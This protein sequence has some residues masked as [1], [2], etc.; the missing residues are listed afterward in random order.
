MSE[1]SAS[2]SWWRTALV[3]AA[4]VAVGG[5]LGSRALGSSQL[6]DF[7]AAGQPI[8]AP[9]PD[10]FSSISLETFEGKLVGMRG[11]PVV[12]NIWASWCAP[13]RTE[14]PLLQKAADAHATDVV[15][16]GVASE[17]TCPAEARRFRQEFGLTYPN[18]GR[19]GSPP[20]DTTGGER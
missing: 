1:R 11:R 12:V 5:W 20:R 13:C 17:R 19:Q 2:S 7:E 10:E 3:I 9:G 18:V 4:L 16:L 8:G 14:M 6:P 15:I